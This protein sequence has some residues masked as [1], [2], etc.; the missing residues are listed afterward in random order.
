MSTRKDRQS[1]PLMLAFR[2]AY[3]ARD[4]K[5]KVDLRNEQGERVIAGRRATGRAS[6][7]EAV[8]RKEVARDLESLMNTIAFESTEDISGFASVRRS[9][10]N[11]G[12]PDIT[13]MT[14]D[15]SRVDSLSGKIRAVLMT[16]EPRLDPRTIR[17]TRDPAARVDEL[18][19]RFLVVADLRCE[20]LNV[21][22][23]FVADVDVESGGIQIN[24]L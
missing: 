23:E 3:A 1:A 2:A 22:V 8:L 21:P 6:V 10:L 5:T 17:A 15:E 14:I 4:A 12:L 7:S 24:R 18:K 16:Y 19:L 9:I 20:P 11:Y 13:Q